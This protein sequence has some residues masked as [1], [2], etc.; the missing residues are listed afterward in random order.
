MREAVRNDPSQVWVRWHAHHGMRLS[1]AC[2]PVRK[3]SAVVAF[4][5]TFNETERTFII[6]GLLLGVDVKNLIVGELTGLAVGA[7]P[8]IG[9][10]DDTSCR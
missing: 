6:D 3:Y 9:A 7:C 8:L 4:E 2:L 5:H 10:D 1:A